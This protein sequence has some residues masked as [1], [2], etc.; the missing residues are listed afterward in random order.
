MEWDVVMG[1]V[2]AGS[3]SVSSLAC[4]SNPAQLLAV[5]E[6]IRSGQQQQQ[7]TEQVF[8]SMIFRK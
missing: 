8:F 7:V 3:G 1:E 5:A 2:E 6:S 4:D